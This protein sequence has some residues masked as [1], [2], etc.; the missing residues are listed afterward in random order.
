MSSTQHTQAQE[1]RPFITSVVFCLLISY[2]I[3]PSLISVLCFP[4]IPSLSRFFPPRSLCLLLARPLLTVNT[5]SAEHLLE[6]LQ[7]LLFDPHIAYERALHRRRLPRFPFSKLSLDNDKE[8]GDANLTVV[9]TATA[10]NAATTSTTDCITVDPGKGS[11]MVKR[12]RRRSSE[13]GMVHGGT[14]LIRPD[15]T[16][17]SSPTSAK[18]L[19]ET[20]LRTG[21]NDYM[22]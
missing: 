2:T 6:S 11:P 22:V 17:S 18:S 19:R 8:H 20:V 9:T 7:R 1:H 21:S 13:L 14:S 10:S 12:R 15:A 16:W 5:Q 3:L 4:R